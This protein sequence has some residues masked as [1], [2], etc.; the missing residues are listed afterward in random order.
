LIPSFPSLRFD[1]IFY[2]CMMRSILVIILL[3][4]W[5]KGFSQQAGFAFSYTGPT[6]ILVG[7]NCVAPLDWGHPNTPTAASNLP[8]GFIVSFDIYSITLGYEIGDLIP[9]GTTITVFYQAL[10]NYGNTAL[11][12][13]NIA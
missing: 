11:F 4:L 12:G 1:F 13:F 3:G 5:G 10:D 8:G 2:F 6:Q 7:P 9:G